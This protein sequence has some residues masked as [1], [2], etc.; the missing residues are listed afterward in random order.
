VRRGGLAL[1]IACAAAL[2]AAAPAP[3]ATFTVDTVLDEAAVAPT[4]DLVCDS[5]PGP[6]LRC[7]LR[8]AIEEA[9]GVAGVDEVVVP[10]L[11]PDYQLTLGGDGEDLG[12]EGDLDVRSGLTITGS[13]GPAIDG[14]ANDRVIHVGPAA[15]APPLTLRGVEIRNG[16]G[17]DRGA[18]VY[19]DSGTLALDA[20]TLTANAAQGIGTA[21]GGGILVEPGG[22]HS[23]TATTIYGNS[24]TGSNDGNGGGVAVEA[25]AA[26]AIDN[27]TISGNTAAGGSG[28]FGGGVY[29]S[30]GSVS[31]SHATMDSNVADGPDAQRGGTL[32]VAGG[33]LTLRASILSEGDGDFAERNCAVLAGTLTTLGANLEAPAPSPT[34][35]E[36]GL[37]GGAFDR[38]NSDAF[39]APLADRGGPTL[40]HALLTSS[41]ALDAIPSCFPFTTD[42]RKLPRPG[43]PACEIGSFE[44]QVAAPPGARCFGKSPTVIADGLAKVIIGSPQGDVIL[45]SGKVELIKGRGGRD[46]ICAGK[47]NDKVY[48]GADA[49]SIAGDA[50]KD[51]LFGQSGADLLLG[52]AGPDLLDG[53]AGRDVLN[54]GARRDTCRGGAADK[55]KN[56]E[57]PSPRVQAAPDA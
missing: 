30:G 42:Q 47:G 28:G 49:D 15:T 17:V 13:G 56:C 20:V 24:A 11:G 19:A 12:A 18:G 8:G 36:C 39:L 1:A 32:A 50:G 5:A 31:L 45:G 54:G 46:L 25:G 34:T 43:G 23:I 48:G 57:Q 55:R 33:N 29:N 27:S 41:P 16:A 9:N 53:G 14:L 26:L 2:A 3:A 35:S 21:L 40:T 4:N 38:L 10:N 52:N 44:R 51:R 37:S 6:A 7:S 22:V